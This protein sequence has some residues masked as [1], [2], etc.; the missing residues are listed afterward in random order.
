MN[1]R[2]IFASLSIAAALPLNAQK[3]ELVGILPSADG[4]FDG[5]MIVVKADGGDKA[6]K[7]IDLVTFKLSSAENHKYEGTAI[8]KSDGYYL[9]PIPSLDRNFEVPYLDTDDR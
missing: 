1:A 5:R 2:Y 3:V 8:K 9:L 4:G 7:D 6:I